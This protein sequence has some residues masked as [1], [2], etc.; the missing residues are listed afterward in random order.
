MLKRILSHLKNNP[1]KLDF[2][3]MLFNVHIARRLRLKFIVWCDRLIFDQRPKIKPDNKLS[4][5]TV[6]WGEKH[7]DLFFKYCYST[8]MQPDNIPKLSQLCKVYQLFYLYRSDLEYINQFYKEEFE[9]LSKYVEIETTFLEDLSSQGYAPNTQHFALIHSIKECIKK[10]SYWFGCFPD[11]IFGNGSITNMYLSAYP[12]PICLA[13][14]NIRV[15]YEKLEGIDF[16]K[17]LKTTQVENNELVKVS[18][19]CMHDSVS[20]CFDDQELNS[21]GDGLS[22]RKLSEDTYAAIHSVP[23][24]YLVFF[25]EKDM[26]FFDQFAFNHFDKLWPRELLKERRIKYVSDSD[27]FFVAEVTFDN[28]KKPRLRENRKYSDKYDTPFYNLGSLYANSVINVWKA[29]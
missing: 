25:T 18:F 13:A 11:S 14:A 19:E 26:R 23:S 7:I 24:T 27:V 16:S 9:I 2:Y 4:L 22:V 8:M 29:K 6:V 28:E 20:N 15:S 1:D 5:C 10:N 17:K 3:R 12:K 21:T